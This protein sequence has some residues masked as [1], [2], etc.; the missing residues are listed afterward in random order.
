MPPKKLTPYQFKSGLQFKHEMPSFLKTMYSEVGVAQPHRNA[1]CGADGDDDSD[2]EPVPVTLPGAS[3]SLSD[4]ANRDA[5]LGDGTDEDDDG[6]VDDDDLPQID[7][8]LSDLPPA[9]VAA[10]LE[11]RKRTRAAKRKKSDIGAETEEPVAGHSDDGGP[12][13]VVFRPKK[14]RKPTSERPP[15]VSASSEAN[16]GDKPTKDKSQAKSKRAKKS[17][18]ATNLHQ[19]SFA[20][21]L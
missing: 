1:S 3:K 20:E 8:D 13:Q 2:A 12:S 6:G 21:E 19:L 5:S 9:E 18:K 17:G 7:V 11:A 15:K 4:P 16:A 14:S 10:Y